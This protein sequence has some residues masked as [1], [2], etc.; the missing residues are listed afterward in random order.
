MDI[1]LLVVFVIV[2]VHAEYEAF[3]V[4]D[5]CYLKRVF[6]WKVSEIISTVFNH[7]IDV[8]VPRIGWV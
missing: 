3:V 7:G 6:F 5:V 4:E 8:D 2:G 1:G